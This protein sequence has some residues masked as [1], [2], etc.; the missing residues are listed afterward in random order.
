MEQSNINIEERVKEDES[1]VY[2]SY[3]TNTFYNKQVFV[4]SGHSTK[5]EVLFQLFG[6]IGCK[7]T[8]YESPQTVDFILLGGTSDYTIP[9]IINF[10]SSNK[11]IKAIELLKNKGDIKFITE[12]SFLDYILQRTNLVND[13]ATMSLLKQL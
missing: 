5:Q 9:E 12:T 11:A 6:N 3:K 2:D 4:L 7:A 1:L 10:G 8:K 13:S